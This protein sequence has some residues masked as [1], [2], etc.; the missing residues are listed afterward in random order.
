[1]S[2]ITLYVSI[3]SG[4]LFTV[5]EILPYISEIKGNSII[6]V[7]LNACTKYGEKK[8]TEM[9]NRDRQIQ[10]ILQIQQQIL[11]QIQQQRS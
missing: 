10:E 1:M 7:L 6:Q 5:S 11:Q 3:A 8:K 4:L 2:D 9:E